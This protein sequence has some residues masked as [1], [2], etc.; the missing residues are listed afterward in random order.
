MKYLSDLN[1]Y[2]CISCSLSLLSSYHICQASRWS[3]SWSGRCRAHWFTGQRLQP[4]DKY[5]TLDIERR[6]PLVYI[7]SFSVWF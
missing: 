4:T 3:D 7:R 2:S 6:L 1:C 5:R